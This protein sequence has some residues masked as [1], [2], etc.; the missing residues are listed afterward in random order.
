MIAPRVKQPSSQRVSA[1]RP[2][3][4]ERKIANE[5]LDSS[6]R[7]SYFSFKLQSSLTSLLARPLRVIS[8]K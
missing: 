4:S 8:E 6:G 2:N 7:A 1:E 3:F 5:G